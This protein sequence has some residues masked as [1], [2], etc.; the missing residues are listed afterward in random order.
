MLTNTGIVRNLQKIDFFTLIFFLP[1]PIDFSSIE[2]YIEKLLLPANLYI[3]MEYLSINWK[4][5]SNIR[6]KLI[7]LVLN[8]DV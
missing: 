4:T 2:L 6:G 5:N 7:I 1:K 3:L 8:F